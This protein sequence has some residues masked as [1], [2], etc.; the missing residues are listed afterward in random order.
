MQVGLARD[1]RVVENLR[2]RKAILRLEN[3]GLRES[4]A[5]RDMLSAKTFEDII[6][7]GIVL[8]IAA[9]GG[10]ALGFTMDE[11]VT[12]GFYSL[13][14]PRVLLKAGHAHGI[15]FALYNLIFGS[16]IDRLALNDTWKLRGSRLA[17]LV[18]IMPV[19]LV[20]RGVTDGAKIFAP[21][22]MIGAVCLLAS[23]AVLIKGLV[24]MKKE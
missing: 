14:L 16:L 1:K 10:M 6:V 20:L 9:F 21:V 5:T 18:F 11:Y 24:N 8:F 13:P 22:V 15:P 23:N 12:R 4:A 17:M 2:D 19:G 7:G 3:L